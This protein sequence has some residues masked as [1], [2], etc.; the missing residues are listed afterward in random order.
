MRIPANGGAICPINFAEGRG[1]KAGG[2]TSKIALG[3]RL[4]ADLAV[5]GRGAWA[6]AI[7]GLFA[8]A[9]VVATVPRRRQRGRVSSRG[10]LE[11]VGG[12]R[13]RK[14]AEFGEL[15]LKVNVVQ[16]VDEMG[17]KR[18]GWALVNRTATRQ[19]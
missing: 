15:K 13:S 11:V 9:P 12:L 18:C 6:D 5:T 19:Q 3:L 1:E 4:E 14:A 8:G 10:P 2:E 17:A 7:L 16:V